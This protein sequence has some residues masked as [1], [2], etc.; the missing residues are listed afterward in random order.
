[1]HAF[2]LDYDFSNNV[3]TLKLKQ[4][5]IVN[6]D[7]APGIHAESTGSG[8]SARGIYAKGSATGEGIYAE[9]VNGI[10]GRGNNGDGAIFTSV[11]GR[12]VYILGASGQ[13][14]LNIAGINK[15]A[16]RF[17]G[18]GTGIP[19]GLEIIA[20]NNASAVQ[21]TGSGLGAG[22][23][24]NAGITGI[25]LDIAGGST[26]GEAINVETSDGDGININASGANKRG[27]Y[28]SGGSSSLCH[29]IQ[30]A[31]GDGA[32]AGLKI[33]GG[34]TG[35][36]LDIGGGATSG[37]AVNI[38]TT[39]GH[40]INLSAVGNNKHGFYIASGAGIGMYLVGGGANP[41]LY[42]VGGVSG[43][44]A[45]FQGGANS[46]D[47]YRAMA[48]GGNG[49]GAS[50]HENGTGLPIFPEV[51]GGLSLSDTVDGVTIENIFTYQLAMI[52]GKFIKNFPNDKD[53][54][55]FKQD[56]STTAFT[57]H[58]TDTERTRI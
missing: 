43:D 38:S 46:G 10:E 56:N 11:S 5:H 57:V 6:G 55:F 50:F 29:A 34:P 19:T 47:G 39:D 2:N 24:I 3:E 45:I 48:S 23:K 15:A 22:L 35:I 52:N 26:S 30:L 1:M 44:G 51:G 40:G 13:Y 32:G 25:G 27:V 54:R 58:V 41:G 37:N 4:L 9:G 31:G 14:G 49:N 53:I 42:A 12:G 21:L 8:S 16:V 33:N 20:G 7:N 36:G 17:E 18:L 28:I